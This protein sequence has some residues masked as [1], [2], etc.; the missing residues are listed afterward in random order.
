MISIALAALTAFNLYLIV[1]SVTMRD[2]LVLVL[3]IILPVVVALVVDVSYTPYT[4]SEPPF[5]SPSPDNVRPSSRLE[6]CSPVALVV[7]RPVTVQEPDVE[8]SS[9]TVASD[10]VPF[11]ANQDD[12]LWPTPDEHF[13]GLGITFEDPEI[14]RRMDMVA[15]PTV[16]YHD[17]FSLKSFIP[18]R[19][20]HVESTEVDSGSSFSSGE[21]T[22]SESLFYWKVEHEDPRVWLDRPVC[23][24]KSVWRRMR[25]SLKKKV[26]RRRF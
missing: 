14:I 24:E 20:G 6:C 3:S 2:I 15:L 22:D 9:V 12:S 26:L 16:V 1:S 23:E 4:R 8:P 7:H 17:F 19:A 18:P 10:P 25:S 11:P 5:S 21:R 13:T